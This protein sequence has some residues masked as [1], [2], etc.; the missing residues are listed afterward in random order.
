MT[1]KIVIYTKFCL[2]CMYPAKWAE[3]KKWAMKNEVKVKIRR[4]A[5]RPDWHI[6]A[7][8][9]YGR[10]NYYAFVIGTD[11]TVTDFIDFDTK[12]KPVLNGKKKGMRND[13]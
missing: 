3:V 7:S 2:P 4:T 8:I 1:G 11:D 6:I 13:M 5:Y 10:P 9:K 12:S